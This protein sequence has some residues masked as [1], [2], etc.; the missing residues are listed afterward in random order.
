MTAISTSQREKLGGG[1]GGPEVRLSF[2]IRIGPLLSTFWNLAWK[3]AMV[4]LF[5]MLA[6]EYNF[7]GYPGD[8]YREWSSWQCNRE[9]RTEGRRDT[10]DL[11][12]SGKSQITLELS[13][14]LYFLNIFLLFRC[15]F[16]QRRNRLQKERGRWPWQELLSQFFLRSSWFSPTLIFSKKITSRSVF[17]LPS[18]SNSDSLFSVR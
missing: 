14:I 1:P 11:W 15:I 4:G 7:S 10:K 3:G 18:E 6:L 5:F 16:Q 2:F 8:A 17:S 9:R 13:W 12:S